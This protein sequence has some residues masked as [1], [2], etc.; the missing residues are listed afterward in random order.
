MGYTMNQNNIPEKGIPYEDVKLGRPIKL[1]GAT[2]LIVGA[3]IGMGVYV[4]I[5][6]IG[7]HM[8]SAMWIAF[9]IALIITILGIAPLIQMSSAMPRAGVAYVYASR[10]LNPLMG[11]ITSSWAILGVAC[12]STYVSMGIAEYAVPYLPGDIPVL[13]I[14][15]LIPVLFFLIYFFGLRLA[16]GLQVIMVALLIFAL[17][18]YGIIGSFKYGMSFTVTL[19]R[20]VGGL[21]MASVLAF[22]AFFGFQVI[23]EMGEEMVNA[24]KNIPL[25]IMIGGL[26]ILVLYIIVGAAFIGSVPY[27]FETI[28]AMKAP[29]KETG[30]AFLPPFW[31]AF[32]SLGA[33]FAGLTSIN[34]AAIGIP[35][36]LYAQSRDGLLPPFIS[37]IHKRTRTPLN[38]VGIY[39][40]L[41]IILLLLQLHID[42]YGVATA[43]GVLIL[44]TVSSIA[45][46]RL[47]TKFPDLYESAYF[48]IPKGLLRVIVVIS[49]ISCLGFV[50]LVLAELPIVGYLYI[51]WT[52]LTIIYYLLRVR[53]LRNRGFDWEERIKKIPGSD[54]E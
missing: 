12:T 44:T 11:M 24:K 31:V 27:D 3:V 2:A 43:V 9:T 5:G 49:I 8:G 52:I 36:E 29:L 46:W 16:T 28:K 1:L 15:L 6:S 19:P 17:L 4:F 42:I 34:A 23:T 21:I 47:P 50:A 38:A 53:W 41:V 40:I 30:E 20:G 54:E 33:L 32:L 7:A 25:S 45:A 39:F 10:L 37:K 18:G 48:K 26:I 35:R 51:G 22:T 14:A 13:V